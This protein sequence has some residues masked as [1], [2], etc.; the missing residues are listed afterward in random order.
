MYLGI[1]VIPLVGLLGG[2]ILE[3]GRKGMMRLSKFQLGLVIHLI[4]YG[5]YEVGI[6]LNKCRWVVGEWFQCGDVRSDFSNV[7]DIEV[8]W[9]MSLISV[10]SLLV[11]IYQLDYLQSE[12]QLERYLGYIVLFSVSMLQ[13]V[14]G[15]EL[16]NMFIGYEI[17][18]VV[19]Y[20][21]IQFWKESIEGSKSSLQAVFINR[22]GDL[23]I[24]LGIISILISMGN[25]GY[26]VIEGLGVEEGIGLI[27]IGQ[28]AKSAQLGLNMWLPNA[29]SAPTPISALLHAATMV[30]V[31]VYISLKLCQNMGEVQKEVCKWIGGSSIVVAGSIGMVQKDVKRI[32][33][34]STGQQLG[35]MMLIS[36]LGEKNGGVF[37][38]VSHGYFK[39]LLFLS[40]GILLSN[41]SDEQDIRKGGGLGVMSEVQK[42]GVVIGSLQ[43]GGLPFLQGFYSK[44]LIIELVMASSKQLGGLNLY[45]LLVGVI[46]VVFTGIYSGRL[47]Q[48]VFIQRQRGRRSEMSQYKEV[49]QVKKYVVWLLIVFQI[50]TGYMLSDY[51]GSMGQ[52]IWMDERMSEFRIV[53]EIRSGF[54]TRLVLVLQI[55]GM[56]I[57]LNMHKI[58][59]R[60]LQQS[61]YNFLVGRWYLDKVQNE[62]FL[63]EG[64]QLGKL[65]YE[66]LD[67][68]VLES[69][70]GR[71][72]QDLIRDMGIGESKRQ[73][74]EIFNYLWIVNVV[75]VVVV[76]VV[77]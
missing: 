63:Q 34:Y 14:S 76:L 2:V 55:G 48:G 5:I 61:I 1:I 28:V 8:I 33:A 24:L 18:G 49:D 22:I 47:I 36:G 77:R 66:G 75:I 29:M 3:V 27:L 11:V 73:T 68:V 23:G 58:G 6:R 57:G 69:L 37:H 10:I 60:W 7:I 62:I 54:E 16:I 19:Q 4:L 41:Y 50:V 64:L 72:F 43:L 44:D 53:Q 32:V 42:V 51:G 15:G 20:L 71:G 46:G 40:V 30:T 17:V 21:L 25:Q 26:N 13:I 38:L 45:Y 35:Y 70:G 59:V 12:K 56:L 31:G 65:Q 67:K 74:G 39:A 52:E 9:M